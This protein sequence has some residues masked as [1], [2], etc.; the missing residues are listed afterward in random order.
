MRFNRVAWISTVILSSIA[1]PAFAQQNPLALKSTGYIEAGVNHA[2]LSNGYQNWN[3]QFVRGMVVSGNN[4]WNA[5]VA[6]WSQF[7]DTGTYGALGNTHIWDQ[8]WHTNVTVGGSSGGF[9][10][11][12]YRVDAFL[13]RKF[14]PDRRLVLTVGT[15]YVEAKDD[16]TDH[17]LYLGATYYAPSNWIFD[18]GVR[19]NKSDPG[20]VYSSYQHVAV[21]YGQNKDQYVTANIA[22]GREAYQIIGPGTVISDF[23]SSSGTLIWRKWLTS[24][25]G[26][27]LRGERYLNPTYSRTGVDASVFFDF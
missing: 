6:H 2:T 22:W 21:T 17:S 19:G 8:D 9:F 3:G 15:G 26:I 25:W 18:A 12:H 4:Y 20:S 24:T 10:L 5:D 11:P 7:G 13:N 16:H 23:S 1:Q 14:L 27:N